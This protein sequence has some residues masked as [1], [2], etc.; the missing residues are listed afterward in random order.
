M[1]ADAQLSGQRERDGPFAAA[2]VEHPRRLA[3]QP[4]LPEPRRDERRRAAEIPE[5]GQELGEIRNELE[6]GVQRRG[7]LLELVVAGQ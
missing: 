7:N 5:I 1:N 3:R 4:E 2:Q 6:G